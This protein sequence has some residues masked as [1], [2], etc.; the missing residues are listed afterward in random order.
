MI[1]MT[2]RM[3]KHIYIS[4]FHIITISMMEKARA[5]QYCERFIFLVQ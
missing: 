1:D 4:I 2:D 3:V 5:E